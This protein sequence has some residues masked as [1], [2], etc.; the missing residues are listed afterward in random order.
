M[1]QKL[2]LTKLLLFFCVVSFLGSCGEVE[3]SHSRPA[4]IGDNYYLIITQIQVPPR[5]PQNSDWS[6]TSNWDDLGSGAPDIFY[7]MTYK[8]QIHYTSSVADDT[9]HASYSPIKLGFANSI[10][11]KNASQYVEGA[12]VNFYNKEAYVDYQ[13]IDKDTVDNDSIGWMR[14]PFMDLKEGLNTFVEDGITIT[15]VVVNTKSDIN[16]QLRTLGLIS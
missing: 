11:T 10:M 2:N 12:M 6:I 1:K 14:I 9:I 13:I 16:K 7:K 15:L 4:K 3:S 5:P 8:G